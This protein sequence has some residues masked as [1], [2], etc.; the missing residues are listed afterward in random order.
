MKPILAPESQDVLDTLA[1]ER[2]LLVFDF[3]GTLAPIVERPA[4]AHMRDS[5]RAL[6]R[7][8][9]LLH[10]CAVVSGRSRADLLPRLAG[11]PFLAVVGCHGAEAGF[12]PVDGRPRAAVAA[13]RSV[14]EAALRGAPGIELE[15][16]GLSLAVHY[17]RAPERGAAR[18]RIREV[19][20]RLAG[21]RVFGGRAVVNVVPAGAPDKGEAVSELAARTGATTVLYAGDDVTDEGAFAAE[22]VLVPVRVGRTHASAAQFYLP[23]QAHVD[24]LLAAIVATRARLDGRGEDVEGLIRAAS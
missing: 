20:D 2:A 10:P 1:R 16:K 9:A 7:V 3:D 21:A 8:A 19:A 5:T 13:W 11:V 17:R 23:A 24:A 15:D 12:G 14:L 4:D 18:R 22:R 6:L